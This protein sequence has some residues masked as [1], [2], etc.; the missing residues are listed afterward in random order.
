MPKMSKREIE[1]VVVYYIGLSEF[2][3]SG[4]LSDYY[5]LRAFYQVDCDLDID[6]AQKDSGNLT[7]QFAEILISQSP[8]NQARILDAVLDRFRI[9][10]AGSPTTRK[11]KLQAKIT[12]IIARLQSESTLLEMVSPASTS[13]V[14]QVALKDANYLIGRG[15]VGS[16]VSKTHTALHGYLKHMCDDESIVYEKNASLPRLFKLL[17]DKHSG[18]ENAGPHQEK[19]DNVGKGLATAIHSLNEIRNQASD[20]HPN[21]ELLDVGDA[22]LA[23]N[24]DENHFPLC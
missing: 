2:G 18:F 3:Y 7:S 17:Q 1:L 12:D 5:D 13:E 6:P 23:I 11:R 14:V 15:R 22:T 24:C 20:A 9:R 21:D 4:N 8:Q 16:A 10:A 19:I